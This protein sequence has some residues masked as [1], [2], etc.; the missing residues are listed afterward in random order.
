M[1]RSAAIRRMT[2]ALVIA[3]SALAAPVRAAVYFVDA[4]RPDDSGAGTS[5]G[6]AKKTI[7]A[8]I[9]ASGAGDTILV[10]YG[11][12][13]ITSSLTLSGKDIRLTS[14]D[15][16]GTGWNDA[17]PQR[18]NCTIDANDNCRVFTIT[19]SAVTTAT[20]IQGFT[21]TDGL[22]EA[23][24]TG[25]H[26][27]GGIYIADASPTIRDNLITG[28][29]GS[30]STGNGGG[31]CYVGSA[32]EIRNNTISSN[33][34]TNDQ[35]GGGGGI[36]VGDGSTG[37]INGNIIEGNTGARRSGGGGGISVGA[38]SPEISN[39]DIRWNYG[40]GSTC[41]GGY[42]GG[43][44]LGGAGSAWVHHN[45][46]R[47][48]GGITCWSS[49]G[50]GD[51][52]G[53]Y[54]WAGNGP[55]IEYN[56]FR[57][58]TTR[59]N[60]AG[61]GNGDG[62][63]VAD[64]PTIRN[65]IF[66]DH[67]NANS[68]KRAIYH[69]GDWNLTVYNNCFYNNPGGLVWVDSQNAVEADPK[70]TDPGNGDFTLQPDSPC[71]DA[72]LNT[73]GVESATDR[74]GNDRLVNGTVDIGAYEYSRVVIW[75]GAGGE[76]SNDWHTPGNWD[77]NDV[78]GPADTVVIPPATPPCIY[79]AGTT[80]VHRL[81]LAGDLS[82]TGGTLDVTGGS[83]VTGTLGHS[84]GVFGGPGP[85][86][87][88]DGGA[89]NWTG[90]T[91]DDD[92][93]AMV[94]DG[95]TLT[96][97]G[98]GVKYLEDRGLV[99]DGTVQVTGNG[100]L[101]M[102][103][104]AT[105]DNNGDFV[106]QTDAD[107]VYVVGTSVFNNAG[108]YRKTGGTGTTEI[109]GNVPF[110]NTGSVNIQSGSWTP[111]SNN[112]T[113][114]GN[115]NVGT[116]GLIEI[117]ANHRLE[118]GASCTGD[119]TVRVTAGTLTFAGTVYATNLEITG[120]TCSGAGTIAPGSQWTIAGDGPKYFTDLDL[121]NGGF[122]TWTGTGLIYWHD[123]TFTNAVGATFVAENDSSFANVIGTNVF[124]NAGTFRKTV[125]SEPQPPRGTSTIGSSVRCNNTGLIDVQEGIL[126]LQGGGEASGTGRF[127]VEPGQQGPTELVFGGGT[128]TLSSDSVTFT[129]AG[130]VRING[131]TLQVDADVN[132][133]PTVSELTAGILQ[134]TG[135]WTIGNGAMMMWRAGDMQG[136]GGTT[137]AAGGMLEPL[138][139][140]TKTLSERTLTN[141]GDVLWLEGNISINN[142]AQVN[143]NGTFQ[144]ETDADI[145]HS[146]GGGT[147]NNAGL[148]RKTVAAGESTVDGSVAFHTT[149]TGTVDI[150]SGSWT[151]WSTSSTT[152]GTLNA[153][154]NG[155][156]ALKNSHRLDDGAACT[157]A[158]TVRASGGTLTFAGTVTTENLELYDG[159]TFSGTGAVAPGS[160]WRIAGDGNKSFYDLA[161]ANGG[162]VTWTGAGAVVWTRSTLTN[163]A[164]G[165]II[166]D[167]DASF[168]QSLGTNVIDNA[169][170]FRKT[171]DGGRGTTTLG[172]N[173]LLNNSG[174]VEVQGGTLLLQGG[175]E[176]SG[177]GTFSVAAG[178]ELVFGGGTYT[179]SSDTVT[180][181]GAGLA[182]VSAGTFRVDADV[183]TGPLFELAAGVLDGAG[184][185]TVGDGS[186]MAWSGGSMEDPGATTIAANGQLSLS[187]DNHKYLDERTVTNN[188]TILW[189]GNGSLSINH[190]APIN[191]NGDW[192]VQTDADVVQSLGG[193]TINNAGTFVKTVATEETVINSP[194]AFHNTGTVDI[195]S[196]SWAPLAAASTTS[197]VLNAGAN[198]AIEIRAGHRFDD[199]A[200]CTG[201]GTVRVAAGGDLTFNGT[202]TTQN[203]DFTGGTFRGAGA[204]A[205]GSLWT[206]SGAN[207]KYFTDLDL[208]NQGQATW[209]GAGN[210]VW[211]RSTFTNGVNGTFI[212]DSDV[213][214]DHSL[215]TNTFINGGTLRKTGNGRGTTEI[216]SG[217]RFETTGAVDVQ[218]GTLQVNGGGDAS[219]SAH[220]NVE[221]GG[222]LVF[223]ANTF[224]ISSDTV[225]FSGGGL[226]KV[227][228]GTLEVN[229]DVAAPPVSELAVGRLDG[230]GSWTVEDGSTMT[231]SGGTMGDAG[232]TAIDA[233]GTLLITG[234]NHKYLDGRTLTNNG[235][236][237]WTDAG[238][239]YIDRDAELN[240]NGEFRVQTDA[241]IGRTLGAGTFN[242]AGVLRKTGTTGETRVNGGVVFHNTG[243]VDI[244]SGSWAPLD[245]GSTN[246][247]I[248]NAGTDGLI[249]VR[250]NHRFDDGT[251]CTGDGTVRVSAGQVTLDGTITTQSLDFA[252]GTF[253]GTA[254]I[255]PGSVWTISGANHKYL[256]D[257]TLANNGEA[258]W[259]GTG[260]LY[261][262]DTT[263]T[264][265]GTFIVGTDANIDDYLGTNVFNNPGTFRKDGTAGT[266]EVVG[267]PFNNSGNLEVRT[268]TVSLNSGGQHLG[269][270]H[271]ESGA[272]VK[273]G[274][275]TH[276]LATGTTF[277]G[278]G[279][280]QLSNGTLDVLSPCTVTGSSLEL[281]GG[282]LQGPGTVTIESRLDW[283]GRAYVYGPGTLVIADNA[284]AEVSGVSAGGGG[285]RG[286]TID[287]FGTFN[288]T[289]TGRFDW[290][291]GGT[292][293]VSVFNNKPDALLDF[294]ADTPLDDYPGGSPVINNEGTIL[295]SAGTGTCS[296]SGVALNNSA[297]VR[298]ASGTLNLAGGGTHTDGQFDTTDKNV[299]RFGGGTHSLTGTTTMTGAGTVRLS[300]GTLDVSDTCTVSAATF[301]F[302]G[303]KL[304]GSGDFRVETFLDWSGPGTMTGT[305]TTT[306]VN[307]AAAEVRGVGAGSGGLRGR[308]VENYGTVTVT[309]TGRFDWGRYSTSVPP[310]T[311][312]NNRPT[313][314]FDFQ[315]DSQIDDYP[316]GAPVLN[317]EGTI[318]KS[319][320]PGT[321]LVSGVEL[322][323]NSGL[324]DAQSGTLRFDDIYTQTSGETR[325]AGGATLR[326]SKTVD[327]QGGTL[328]GTGTVDGN[329]ANAGTTSPGASPGTLTID[330]DYTQTAGGNLAIEIAGN[331]AGT[332]DVL[333]VTGTASL[334]GTVTVTLDAF[335]PDAGDTFDFLTCTTRTGMFAVENLQTAANG[336]WDLQ[337]GADRATLS[338]V[339]PTNALTVNHVGHGSTNPAGTQDIAAGTDVPISATADEG[340]EFQYWAATDQLVVA[341]P[342]AADTTVALNGDGTVTARFYPTP[343]G[344]GYALELDGADDYVH[345]PHA[346]TLNATTELTVEVWVNL[347]DPGPDQK[348]VCKIETGPGGY[349]LA[350][351]G[352][353]LYV[354]VRDSAG[355]YFS[356]S[357]GTVSANTWT[358]LAFTWQTGGR[359]IGYVSGVEVANIA[360][361]ANPIGNYPGPLVLGATSWDYGLP[362]TGQIDQ[363]R[364]WGKTRTAQEIRDAMNRILTTGERSDAALAACYR[365][366][367]NEGTTAYDLSPNA[368]DGTLTNMARGSGWVL[369]T[370]PIGGASHWSAG[371]PDLSANADV[372]A[373]ID[374]T[375]GPG[376]GA[377]S[378]A[379][380]VN[381]GPIV[382]D[383][384][385][386]NHPEVYWEL[387][388][389]HND[390]FSANVT[391]TY[392]AIP[393]IRR[394]KDLKLFGR[395]TA[396]DVWAEIPEAVVDA[397]ID[398][399]DG[400]GSVTVPGLA[401]FSQFILS[402]VDPFNT[403]NVR[404]WYRDDFTNGISDRFFLQ[405]KDL[406]IFDI[407]GTGGAVTISKPAG[408]DGGLNA[409]GVHF[410]LEPRD[411]F[412][413]SV[414]FLDAQLAQAGGGVGNQAQFNFSFGP[415]HLAIVRSDEAA[416][417]GDNVHVYRNPPNDWAGEQAYAAVA[418]NMS[419]TRA[420]TQLTASVD[421]GQ[422]HQQDYN[423]NP[424]VS[425]LFLLQNNATTDAVSITYDNFSIV[426]DSIVEARTPAAPVIGA[427]TPTTDTTPTWTWAS[428]GVGNGNFRYQLDGE[429][430]GN[431]TVTTAESL[432]PTVPLADGVYTLYVQE[433]NDDGVW[434]PSGTFDV[435]IDNTPP[436]GTVDDGPG[437]DLDAQD[438][439]T[440]VEA[441]WPGL[442]DPLS[443]V[444]LYEWAVGSTP[445]GTDLQDFTD[446]GTATTADNASLAFTGGDSF[447]VSVRATNGVGLQS[448]PISDG[449]TVRGLPH[450]E[451]FDSDHLMDPALTT[452][453]WSTAQ[454]R[455]SLNGTRDV[456]ETATS[457]E[458]DTEI[459]NLPA[460]KVTAVFTTP[461]GTSIRWLLTNNGGNDW[462]EAA[463]DAWIR[464][465]T[466][467][468]DVRWRAVLS[469][470]GLPATP[471]ITQVVIEAKFDRD[472]DGMD[473]DWE[474]DNGLNPT[475]DDADGNPDNDG[476]TNLEEFN[477]G[478]DPFDP[479]TD[480]DGM[481]DGWE[482]ANGLDPL[483]DD[484]DGNPD[485]DG[486]TNGEEYVHGTDP[487]DPDTDDDGMPDGW[488]V[489]NQLDPTTD[490]SAADPD[491]D[492]Y[493]NLAEYQ[494]Q[495][496]PQDPT[497]IPRGRLW[498]ANQ[499]QG[500]VTDRGYAIAALADGSSLVAGRFEG[501]V[502]FGPGGRPPVQLSSRGDSD[503]WVAKY[504]LAGGLVWVR[505]AGGEEADEAWG[506]AALDDGGF[507]LTGGFSDSATFGELD[508]AGVVLDSDGAMDAFVA[509]YDAHGELLWAERAGG[510]SDDEGFG[511][512]VMA[513]GTSVVTGVFGERMTFGNG[514]PLDSNDDSVD[515]F[516]AKYDGDGV[517]QWAVAA[518]GPSGDQGEAVQVL[519]DG[520]SLVTG[521]FRDTATFGTLPGKQEQLTTGA[522]PDAF[523]ARYNA[524][525][526]L[527]WARGAGGTGWDAGYGIAAL[528]DGSALV[529]GVF[530]GQA[531]FGDAIR[532]RV[533]TI[534]DSA[535]LDDVFVARYA[536]DGSVDWAVG[537]GGEA[538]DVAGGIAALPDGSALL[539]GH[540]EGAA[541]FGRGQAGETLL[542]AE[543]GHDVFVARLD[544]V[545]QLTW[546]KRGGGTA[547]DMGHAI[548]ALPDGSALVTGQF[549][550]TAMFGSGEPRQALVAAPGTESTFVARFRQAEL[551]GLHT[552]SPADTAT[553]VPLYEALTVTIDSV[554]T[555]LQEISDLGRNGVSADP[556]YAYLMGQHHVTVQQFAGFLNDLLGTPGFG[557]QDPVYVDVAGQ[558]YF[559]EAM[560]ADSLLF[561]P[562]QCDLQEDFG[563]SY[564][565]EYQVPTRQNGFGVYVF[566]PAYGQH[567]IV[568]VSWYGAL[569]YCNWLS[570]RKGLDAEQ[571]CY[572][573]GPNAADW[574]PRHLSAAQ[575]QDGFSA[576]E[577]QAWLDGYPDGFR[578]PMDDL[579]EGL[580]TYNEFYKAAAWDG[581]SAQA[582]GT[583]TVINT[584]DDNKDDN[585]PVAVNTG[586]Q[587][588]YMLDH[589]LGNA[590]S[591]MTDTFAAGDTRQFAIRGWGWW[592]N[593]ED[594]E[595]LGG[596]GFRWGVAP[597]AAYCDVGLRVVTMRDYLFEVQVSQDPDFTGLDPDDGALQVSRSWYPELLPDTTYHWRVRAK[598]PSEMLPSSQGWRGSTAENTRSTFT[599]EA[600]ELTEVVIDVA[601]G[602]NLI[603]SSVHP[604][605]VDV[606]RAVLP[607]EDSALTFWGWDMLEQ[608][609][610]RSTDMDPGNGYWFFAW[611]AG[612]I[613]IRGHAPGDAQ[614]LVGALWN[615]I[616]L[617]QNDPVPLA[618]TNRRDV[619]IINWWDALG[620]RYATETEQ[621][622]PLFGYWVRV[623]ESVEGLIELLK[624]D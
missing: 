367:E 437:A 371:L 160:Q 226:V 484:A 152:A 440:T 342:T 522:E 255:A 427:A 593:P 305:G 372:T 108:E 390:A 176:A 62:I 603:S 400:Q 487:N 595:A 401:S 104:G 418:G 290:G 439:A 572:L 386:A 38:A 407:D 369:S 218:G 332:F 594:V 296:L 422:I 50:Y 193:G 87:V 93:T 141:D 258:T 244:Q 185:W 268:G 470:T 7:Q 19:G 508:R 242:N 606:D 454:R 457:L 392:D 162:Q 455:L 64:G 480:D 301:D 328:T 98:D 227:G 298:S 113:T 424:L 95:A 506:I 15:G 243:T 224:T 33:Q 204:I 477:N 592:N 30:N 608:S 173:V 309:A 21:I 343:P 394:E 560:G 236:A 316:G 504:D 137:V 280:I 177:G 475:V 545:G 350:V 509:R 460:A 130:M 542:K 27:G 482:V 411:D 252:G 513:D 235:I 5:W 2:W 123:A 585:G 22:A 362:T 68:D 368:H 505:Q 561:D 58:N 382:T 575:W 498:W 61:G 179:L 277:S 216:E 119:G 500:T 70:L 527:S 511:V 131:G 81:S 435:T 96:L 540:F 25:A 90:G 387:W 129:G 330:G 578:L 170:T 624:D 89:W 535:G 449:V 28:N 190:T 402:D 166:A 370:A 217:V 618:E 312:F 319:A 16:D 375:S 202:I 13:S 573:E 356:F 188:G 426:A 471:E 46:I 353:H 599:T 220:F 125:G 409:A 265:A 323:N 619:Q 69:H 279:T 429:D 584:W 623:S 556:Q 232:T 333:A 29:W 361:G 493:S 215:G 474:V 314:I 42:G 47:Y 317:N 550:G 20:V 143:N 600:A 37:I 195:Q 59:P 186:T 321:Y 175:G 329:V 562:A 558:A 48:N 120:G 74:A 581:G 555:A 391:F 299:V 51:G 36:Y 499:T 205:A 396:A 307:G 468:S 237:E 180:F 419:M 52:G 559:N 256:S 489:A 10:K 354:E 403:F 49:S 167:S 452:A 609:Y 399:T 297:L 71:I 135:T 187:G 574:R 159:G 291:D 488:E 127:N 444:T 410:A 270:F 251:N 144:M 547:E 534:L 365:F 412:E 340:H 464:F 539:T 616:G 436:A 497:S 240:N 486:L 164:G 77:I 11:T 219:G 142:G 345:V 26:H 383:G 580:S 456:E 398:N 262:D 211:T 156:I 172:S 102:N 607:Q 570:R 529:T 462:V 469:S 249:E 165:A 257:L 182:K 481:P 278:S 385:L 425:L 35:N 223:G 428:G 376:A 357:E 514:T 461:A 161:L 241:D 78:P 476:L 377:L 289:T 6:A 336:I 537:L 588:H 521:L 88:A 364:V 306:L 269:N 121:T 206:L 366:D 293:A 531:T 213:K 405:T 43:I 415:Q 302:S 349:V 112:S 105:I 352:G 519:A 320:G 101:S 408:G 272:I 568:G 358:H 325:L 147:V 622:N 303:G 288:V 567:P 12:Y 430:P 524:D 543:G 253:K 75:T 60:A 552:V 76:R 378:A 246:S 447:W 140:G 126:L 149:A 351:G 604:V 153:G 99:N 528:E 148:F 611:G 577:R 259:T 151:P 128:Y 554:P 433:Q 230:T 315:V 222:E 192:L 168:T 109:H 40:G 473:D 32:A 189:T 344:A 612:Q 533:E 295:K 55:V 327:I 596:A 231:W 285:I 110:H 313:G 413:A 133:P 85:L 44:H 515:M 65:N 183:S 281:K 234:A 111:R 587:N 245:G 276:T 621:F 203:L 510:T 201:A 45:V 181:T 602:W 84:G 416:F 273:F 274:G 154:A 395:G 14:D 458:I 617:K 194:I 549:A 548:A 566:D 24:T 163:A 334:A 441:N 360:A 516:L 423:A 571:W 184:T 103:S 107:I 122:A 341:D 557:G 254:A 304:D 389:A 381:Q 200:S 221:P 591:W 158:G 553:D 100:N 247:G 610:V 322:N 294:Q 207:H 359:M 212:A 451:D 551:L 495:S 491:D 347:P 86:T 54:V 586:L 339:E 174:T 34:G 310:D 146:L 438:S 132:A 208:T 615:L 82:I 492:Q 118:H 463:H 569:K 544:A 271:A 614:V 116:N 91:L 9:D 83:T 338:L 442:V 582:L 66:V 483:V 420:G 526:S 308:T 286:R 563:F 18:G 536:P 446:V 209:T 501:D 467:G 53:L 150:Q 196:G 17:A 79:S 72:G 404:Q 478:T 523:V 157:G 191:N 210:I 512:D 114:S 324:V 199:G 503:I 466:R 283:T 115:L 450:T 197:G 117:G 525:G 178:A 63:W 564:G 97:G 94:A 583:S 388:I 494:G 459:T 198:G 57:G 41:G 374:W 613:V 472:D 517:L 264:N 520:S 138:G 106:V 67:D 417:G 23:E 145:V 248:L 465:A 260:Y 238:Y 379:I 275:G 598:Y 73:P 496:D 228:G 335:E 601:A 432:T 136:S 287:N 363:V 546:A 532:G 92:G 541:T 502:T 453:R 397:G 507:V 579:S 597:Q 576:A 292:R 346:G 139:A 605:I 337:Y 233:N 300:T 530:N 263:F 229:A 445:G 620:G 589:A 155:V 448:T 414:D 348:V 384:L 590:W 134:G 8:A 479:D 56:V 431:W 282:T 331:T 518:G 261:F 311:V 538:P 266:T 355:G 373:G 380:Q 490:D 250:A 4:A 421:G 406:A 171:T 1:D 485:G 239:L 214:L 80:T 443:G 31:I 326:S 39:N 565:I 225:G 267:I 393:G 124:S 169:G 318:R 3:F 434:G 284:V